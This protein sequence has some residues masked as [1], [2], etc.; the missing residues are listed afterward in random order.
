[1]ADQNTP[2]LD[3]CILQNQYQGLPTEMQAKALQ[4]FL[5]QGAEYCAGINNFASEHRDEVFRC[6]HSLKTMSAMV[7]AMR[8]NA[9]CT[10]FEL[11]TEDA[12]RQSI[13]EQLTVLWPQ[14]EA[15]VQQALKA[16]P[17]A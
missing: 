9:L 14:T 8:L 12:E 16:F 13:N 15:A 4:L 6:C 10:E 3:L 7:G 17:G 1:M 11:A 5:T 2:I